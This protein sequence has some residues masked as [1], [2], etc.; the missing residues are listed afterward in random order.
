MCTIRV[1]AAVG[2]GGDNVWPS[3]RGLEGGASRGYV[4]G[5]GPMVEVEADA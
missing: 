4:N 2:F 3:M 1:G 5:A